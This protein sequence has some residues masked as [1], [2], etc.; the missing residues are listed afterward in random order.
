MGRYFNREDMGVIKT[1]AVADL[2][3]L[4]GNPLKDIEQTQQIEGV[5]LSKTYLPKAYI[6][7]ELKKLEKAQ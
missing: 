1:G 4:N 3:L 2:L 7:N 6:T 5:L